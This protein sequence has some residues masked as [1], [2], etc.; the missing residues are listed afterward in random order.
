MSD[1]QFRIEEAELAVAVERQEYNLLAFL[2]PSVSIDGN[3]WCVL[4]GEDLQNGVAGF[5]D[6][7]YLA[8]LAF[9]KEWNR[10]LANPHPPKPEEMR[11]GQ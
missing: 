1:Y 8:V 6:T 10:R 3:Q 11:D 9:N 4:Y 2:N 5:G 7:P